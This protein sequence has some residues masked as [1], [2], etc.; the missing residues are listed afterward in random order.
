MGPMIRLT[1]L[2]EKQDSKG[3]YYLEGSFGSGKVYVFDLTNTKDDAG[4]DYATQR[5]EVPDE[6]N[7]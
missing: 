7:K 5:G 2:W 4:P 1:G 3:N 6:F